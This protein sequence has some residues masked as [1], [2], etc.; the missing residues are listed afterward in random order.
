MRVSQSCHQR[1]EA[2][3]ETFA[4]HQRER[5]EAQPV[6]RAVERDDAL[7]SGGGAGKFQRAFHRL[8]A[9]VA[10]ENGVEMRRRPFRERLGEQS[11]EERAIHLHH[12][13]QIEIEHVADRLS[14]RPDDCG[15]Y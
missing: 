14:S 11:A 1:A 4:A 3:G 6:K 15:R 5:T 7:P 13:R 2:F 10:E 8:R 9:G 12:V